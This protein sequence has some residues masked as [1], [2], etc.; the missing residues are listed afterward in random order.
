MVFFEAVS[1]YAAYTTKITTI[2]LV[3]MVTGFKVK[4]SESEVEKGKG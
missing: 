2:F 4:S 3:Q 1:N